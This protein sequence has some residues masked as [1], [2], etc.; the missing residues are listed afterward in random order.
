MILEAINP[1][2]NLIFFTKYVNFPTMCSGQR[3]L[4]PIVN[5]NGASHRE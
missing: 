5:S 2:K 3:H 4:E 1:I